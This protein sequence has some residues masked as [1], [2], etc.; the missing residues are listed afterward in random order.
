MNKACARSKAK[1]KKDEINRKTSRNK[2]SPKTSDNAEVASA[3]IPHQINNSAE[4]TLNG[5]YFIR[6][7]S[8]LFSFPN[9][10]CFFSASTHFIYFYPQYCHLSSFKKKKIF[11]YTISLS[12]TWT[13]SRYSVYLLR[14]CFLYLQPFLN[15]FIVKG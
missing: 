8:F 5:K 13:L 2:S 6:F 3:R 9:L 14:I 11:F 10:L 12:S 1:V 7:Y 15:S 4:I